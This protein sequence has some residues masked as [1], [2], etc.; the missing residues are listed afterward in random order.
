MTSLQCL[1]ITPSI[2]ILKIK[3]SQLYVYVNK[4]GVSVYIWYILYIFGIIFKL[5]GCGWID[6]LAILAYYSPLSKLCRV[7]GKKVT[8]V[9]LVL[10][11]LALGQIFLG[12]LK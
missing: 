7:N 11:F 2:V 12:L 5:S 8:A 4:Q 9:V 1:F 6:F 10:S 3:D